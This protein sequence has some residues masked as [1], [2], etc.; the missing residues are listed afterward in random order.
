MKV[1]NGFCHTYIPHPSQA[2]Q[3]LPIQETTLLEL[4]AKSEDE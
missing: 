1:Y 4:L 2:K 3:I